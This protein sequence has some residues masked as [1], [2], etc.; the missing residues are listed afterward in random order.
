MRHSNLP[1]G[2]T[3]RMIEEAASDTEDYCEK[4][5]ELL[6]DCECVKYMPC[7]IP[8]DELITLVKV[9]PTMHRHEWGGTPLNLLIERVQQYERDLGLSND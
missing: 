9:H 3:D 5:N 2:V 4:C 8:T 1:P 6:V 7:Y